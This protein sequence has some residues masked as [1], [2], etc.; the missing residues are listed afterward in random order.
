VRHCS[1][2]AASRN[3]KAAN[4]LHGLQGFAGLMAR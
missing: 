4:D 2:F 1:R 3:T